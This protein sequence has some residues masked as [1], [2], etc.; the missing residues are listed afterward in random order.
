[1]GDVPASS[2]AQLNYITSAVPTAIG[3]NTPKASITTSESLLLF[4]ASIMGVL[5]IPPPCHPGWCGPVCTTGTVQINQQDTTPRLNVSPSLATSMRSKHT[6][7]LNG[8]AIRYPAVLGSLAQL[9][10]GMVASSI[11][12]RSKPLQPRFNPFNQGSLK[13]DTNLLKLFPSCLSS[14]LKA[15]I[16]LVSSGG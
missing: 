1:M 12:A 14:D 10:D 9:F 6:S 13:L 3:Y 5:W 8:F 16:V 2:H 11:Q 7:L 4:S 15:K